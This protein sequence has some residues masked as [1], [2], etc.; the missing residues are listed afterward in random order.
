MNL[1]KTIDASWASIPYY[2]KPFPHQLNP[3]FRGQLGFHQPESPN[4]A[5]NII[6]HFWLH[7]PYSQYP[8]NQYWM[9]VSSS[10][11]CRGIRWCLKMPHYEHAL[12]SFHPVTHVVGRV[13]KWY[14]T[15]IFRTKSHKL[16]A[17]LPPWKTRTWNAL[18]PLH[19]TSPNK[20]Q[21]Y[22]LVI[23]GKALVYVKREER[24]FLIIWQFF[25]QILA[26]RLCNLPIGKAGPIE[27]LSNR[28]A[29]SKYLNF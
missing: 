12:P 27:V 4:P 25:I 19:S 11:Y 24:F 28:G 26:Q 7:T 14:T 8:V 5:W 2:T 17:C 10:C 21:A 3:L 15:S 29:P 20:R 23:V 9:S 18:L 22:F 1:L 13:W 16:R 6:L